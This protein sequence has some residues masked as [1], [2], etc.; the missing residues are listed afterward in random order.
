LPL[1]RPAKRII[2][3]PMRELRGEQMRWL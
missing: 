2:H 3:C 1:A